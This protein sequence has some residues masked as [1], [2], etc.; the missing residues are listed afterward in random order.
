MAGLCKLCIS[1]QERLL[2]DGDGSQVMC[3]HEDTI[4]SESETV[5]SCKQHSKKR[6]RTNFI[7]LDEFE[8]VLSKNKRKNTV[9]WSSVP[10]DVIFKVE[11]IKEV[12]I[13]KN[14]EG[15]TSRIAELK[16]EGGEVTIAWLPGIIS[17]ELNN[18]EDFEKKQVYIRSLGL[19]D[20]K[21]GT[22]KYFDF[23]FIS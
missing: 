4:Q 19:K 12:R 3:D 15:M 2:A 23:D 1:I 22:R 14:G 16:N 18:I 21:N 5:D 11:E 10:L 13:A 8:S 20:N 17:K 7:S 6:K 9:K